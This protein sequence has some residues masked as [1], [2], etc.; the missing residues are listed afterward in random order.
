MSDAKIGKRIKTISVVLWWINV[1]IVIIAFVAVAATA[2][3]W[4]YGEEVVLA[5]I[6]AAVLGLLEIF[7]T[8][9]YLLLLRGF[10]HLIDTTTVLTQRTKAIEK[11][12]DCLQK[13]NCYMSSQ[14]SSQTPEKKVAN[15][16]PK[17][18]KQ[19]AVEPSVADVKQEN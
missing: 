8:Y 17:A 11:Q 15:E 13:H 4:L 2:R 3:Y 7:I 6:G 9:F 19:D 10:G 1:A 12:I 16:G 14:A 5:I 18:E